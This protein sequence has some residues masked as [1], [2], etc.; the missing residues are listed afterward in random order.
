MPAPLHLDD[1]ERRARLA[2][3]HGLHP[4]H[5]LTSAH[6]AAL[7]MTAL[8]ATDPSTVHLAVRARTDGVEVAD[9]D[10]ALY[11]E[12]SVVK[13]LSMR[14]TLW[15]VPRE[16]LP[17]VLGSASA[18]VALEQRRLVAKDA[19]AHGLGEDGEAWLA[20]ACEAV[21]VRLAGRPPLS[22]RALR[23]QVPELSGT[24]TYAPDKTYG[25]T[26]HIAPR[27]LTTLGAEGR[28]VRGPNAGQWKAS[29]P[30]W[31]LM[32][33]WLGEQVTPLTPEEGYA[34]LVRHWLRTFGP[35]TLED[36]HWWLGSTKT[37]ARAA[38][39]AVDAV[40]VRLDRDRTG[41]VLPDD[42]EPTPAPEPWAALLPTLDPTTMGWK[43]R[44]F[45]LDPARTRHLFDS[46]GNGGSTAWWD[47]QVV[48]AWVQD[49]DGVV[50]VVVVPGVDPGS[51][52][53][54]ALAAEAERL[55]TWLDGVVITNVYKSALMKGEILP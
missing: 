41:W 5:R 26:S 8:H 7:A 16:L 31:T 35:G 18:R 33:D 40:E 4:D 23:E 10:R 36:V 32:A 34:V 48:G 37:A 44:D 11:D 3:R 25:G 52:A 39:A 27:V 51:A 13:Q 55:T 1:R 22:S 2:V 50:E 30:E 9:V 43:E 24:Y 19:A 47:G 12:R 53:R 17:A 45:Y 21:L 20:R 42:L 38:L 29:I 49:P 28:I 46:N 6:E 14:R 54:A 15:A